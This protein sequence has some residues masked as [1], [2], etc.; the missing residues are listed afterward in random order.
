[1]KKGIIFLYTAVCL[2]TTSVP[3]FAQGFLGL[4]VTSM[5]GYPALPADTAFEG[6]S[7]N[8]D[9]LVYNGSNVTIT[10]TIMIN[11]RVD[12]VTAMVASSPVLPPMAPGDSLILSVSQYNFDPSQY[13]AGNNIV[14]VW[15]S[16]NGMSIPIDTAY[17]DVFFVPLNSLSSHELQVA[18]FQIYPVPV[19][20]ELRL[21][22][23]ADQDL[24]YVRIFD[25]SGRLCAAFVP[26]Q[27][28]RF[29]VSFLKAGVYFIEIRTPSSSGC[30]RFIKM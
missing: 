1:M 18:D 23:L 19:H 3:S 24:E 13:K 22:G 26:G 11:L 21:Q 10:N 14:V 8:F 20:D 17:K 12:T 2:L 16:V 30:T 7:Y 15:P 5:P 29:D 6:V 4:Q 9:I 25:T 27:R 28:R